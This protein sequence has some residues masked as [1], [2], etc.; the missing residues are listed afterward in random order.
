MEKVIEVLEESLKRVFANIEEQREECTEERELRDKLCAE[1]AEKERLVDE[2]AQALPHVTGAPELVLKDRLKRAD[3]RIEDARKSVVRANERIKDLEESNKRSLEK[4]K[5][6]EYS[7]AR[8]KGKAPKTIPSKVWKETA[9]C[10]GW[11]KPLEIDGALGEQP[12]H[13]MNIK[14]DAQ[15]IGD[16]FSVVAEG[17]G[18]SFVERMKDNISALNNAQTR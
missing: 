2:I 14:I 12:I 8:L 18:K 9:C 4:V 3:Q 17:V 1:I 6:Y 7:I 5:E 11:V 10:G 13:G 16:T 15:V